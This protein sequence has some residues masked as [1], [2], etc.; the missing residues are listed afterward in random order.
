[1]PHARHRSNQF[2]SKGSKEKRLAKKGDLGKRG[3]TSEPR[4]PP[5]KR[6]PYSPVRDRHSLPRD[7]L[8]EACPYPRSLPVRETRDLGKR[9]SIGDESA[10]VPKHARLKLNAITKSDEGAQ[11]LC[12][13]LVRADERICMD[14]LVEEIIRG[15]GALYIHHVE[16][17]IK[18]RHR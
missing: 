16:S 15:C 3:S 6:V 17:P 2:M 8:P 10:S 7:H 12:R 14:Y 9:P 11:G 18:V 4:S 1:M 13:N 5:S